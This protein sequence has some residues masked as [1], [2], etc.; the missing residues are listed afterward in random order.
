VERLEKKLDESTRANLA[1]A[2]APAPAPAPA[3]SPAQAEQPPAAEASA[4]EAMDVVP[5]AAAADDAADAAAAGEGL[6]LPPPPPA[7]SQQAQQPVGK[8]IADELEDARKRLEASLRDEAT[9]NE[10]VE[11]ELS[12]QKEIVSWMQKVQIALWPSNIKEADYGR[13]CGRDVIPATHSFSVEEVQERAMN[14]MR[15]NLLP[16]YIFD[17]ARHGI[18]AGIGDIED[19][20][21]VVE[22]FR[23]MSWCNVTMQVM[24][25]PITTILLRKLISASEGLKMVDDKLLRFFRNLNLR[26][27]NWKSKA[28]RL[29]AQSTPC[30][31]ETPKLNGLLLEGN[32]IP[33]SSRIKDILR[34][35]MEKVVAVTKPHPGEEGFVIPA[36]DPD[37]ALAA[38][39]KRPLKA[40]TGAPPGMPP[41]AAMSHDPLQYHSS[42]DESKPRSGLLHAGLSQH[43]IAPPPKVWPPI[44]PFP[45][46]NG[47]QPLA[48][49]PVP[50]SYSFD[51]GYGNASDDVPSSSSSSSSLAAAVGS[52]GAAGETHQSLGQALSLTAADGKRGRKPK[53]R[54]D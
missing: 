19:I 1:S 31:M 18:E 52:S 4:E 26:S 20:V 27:A 13:P 47:Q 6:P 51:Q 50:P 21:T 32:Q 9:A 46:G 29:I 54:K 28:R 25:L 45:R 8:S 10:L 41:I 49:A 43:L 36:I 16:P 53:V 30:S 5:P 37:T 35:A 11:L 15:T 44:I 14:H 7:S 3:A 2:A 40:I 42:D 22:A 39:A 33:I 17:L 48:P 24:R 34:A 38:N 12:H 23:W